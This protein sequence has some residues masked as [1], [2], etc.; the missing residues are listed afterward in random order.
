MKSMIL[1]LGLVA[2]ALVA[3]PLATE[4]KADS[5]IYPTEIG[6]QSTCPNQEVVWLQLQS[7]KYFHKSAA[8]YGSKDGA[9]ACVAKARSAG[10]REVKVEPA[11]P[12][13]ADAK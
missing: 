4:A 3:G 10:Y 12:V 2:A 5:G 9:Y 11:A 8:L 6:A 13:T 7:Q 1:S